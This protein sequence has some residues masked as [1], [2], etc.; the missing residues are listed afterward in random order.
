MSTNWKAG[1]KALCVKPFLGIGKEYGEPM[2]GDNPKVGIVYLVTGYNQIN[3]LYLAGLTASIK[4]P[5]VGF[6]EHKFRKIV[7]ACDRNEREQTQLMP[8]EGFWQNRP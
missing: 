3:G 4:D 2:E 6:N 5:E 8:H 1:E 7:P